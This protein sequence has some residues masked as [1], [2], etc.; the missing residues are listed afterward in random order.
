MITL[1][2]WMFIVFVLLVGIGIGMERFFEVGL[3]G[4]VPA[5]I[6]L[7]IALVL[8]THMG[9][10]KHKIEI[11]NELYGTDYTT[12]EAFWAGSLIQKTYEEILVGEKTRQEIEAEIDLKMAK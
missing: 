9:V 12:E 10:R 7:F 8:F 2:V 4:W 11:F 5:G 1:I 3:V 6:I